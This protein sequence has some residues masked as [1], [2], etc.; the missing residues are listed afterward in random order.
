M[1]GRLLNKPVK[2]IHGGS[3]ASMT[4]TLRVLIMVMV[5][6]TNVGGG[7]APLY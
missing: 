3:G 2:S 4:I 6:L 5:M 7:T 1:V